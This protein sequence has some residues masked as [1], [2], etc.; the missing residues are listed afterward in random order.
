MSIQGVIFDHDGTLIDS[1]SCHFAIWRE[2]LAHYGIALEEDEYVTKLN[3]VPT[4]ENA[5]YLVTHYSLPCDLATLLANKQ[6]KTNTYFSQNLIPLMPFAEECV[7][8]CHSWHLKLAIATGADKRMLEQCIGRH[9]CN[10]LFQ[11]IASA[12]R[13]KR[14]KPEPDVYLLALK[15]LGLAAEYAIAVEDSPTGIAAAK[16]ANLHCIAVK[17]R[18]SKNQDLSRADFQVNNLKEA[19]D[20]IQTLL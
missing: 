2:T 14:N 17:N 7:K 13:V 3:G 19:S 20:L 1:E 5:H 12:D 15:E 11:S 9:T 8:K 18:Y 16:A 10:S 6:K 4:I